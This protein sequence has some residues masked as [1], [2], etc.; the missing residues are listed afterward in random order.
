MAGAGRPSNYTQ[1]LGDEICAQLASGLSLRTVCKAK[2]MPDAS[3]V[4]R[5]LR[6]REDFRKQYAQAKEESAD[7][8]I[9][10][11]TDTG[12]EAIKESKI[13]D[14]KAAGGVVQAYRLKADNIKWFLSKIKP[15]KYGDKLDITSDG[16]KL[17]TPILGGL[18][19]ADPTQVAAAF[20]TNDSLSI[21]P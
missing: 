18:S 13:V 7:A 20:T 21:G 19:V 1:D 8:L 17:P 11:L 14:P 9:E 16:E 2:S 3:T 5:W 10:D 4:F 12:E 15:K 6:E